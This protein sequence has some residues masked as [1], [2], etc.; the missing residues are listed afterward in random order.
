MNIEAHLGHSLTRSTQRRLGVQDVILGVDNSRVQDTVCANNVEEPAAA[1][2]G[3]SILPSSERRK[4]IIQGPI[5]ISG[6]V[7][8]RQS[9]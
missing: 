5:C 9:Q 8:L 3:L 7:P 4:T 2:S 1:R 6:I